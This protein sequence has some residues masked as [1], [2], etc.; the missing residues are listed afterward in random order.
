M[1]GIRVTR[2][3]CRN[4]N[5]TAIT[6]T[7]ASIRVR[8]TSWIDSLTKVVLSTGKASLTP[9]G[10]VD[11]RASARALTAST[12]LRALAPGASCTATPAAG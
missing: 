1:A 6:S 5:I 9:G 4:R 2:Q 11:C 3:F 7:M 12:T 10:K 8:I